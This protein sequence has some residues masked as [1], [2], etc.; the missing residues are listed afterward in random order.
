MVILGIDP[1][2]GTVGYGAIEYGQ[3][4]AHA[5]LYGAITTAPGRPLSLRLLEIQRDMQTLL[6]RV[7]PDAVAVEELYF[8]NNV[9]TGIQVAQARGVILVSCAQRGL[10]PFEYSPSQVKQAVV[11]YGKA[12]KRQMM[13]LTRTILHLDKLPRPDDAADALAIA[14]CHAHTA[15][16]LLSRL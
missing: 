11:G 1:G 6:D 5:L 3:G 14:L 12:E 13:E 9:T 7:K 15:G 4:T 8:N 10:T 16:S 2:Y